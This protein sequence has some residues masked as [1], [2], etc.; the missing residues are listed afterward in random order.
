M[1]IPAARKT[2]ALAAVFALGLTAACGSDSDGDKSEDTSRDK[3][4]GATST[5]S[6]GS[7]DEGGKGDDGGK[8]GGDTPEGGDGKTLSAGQLDKVALATADVKDQGYKV[9]SPSPKQL[10]GRG[11]ETAERS[12]CQPLA[13]VIGGDPKPK[14]KHAAYRQIAN[15]KKAEAVPVFEYLNAHGTQ[16]NAVKTLADLRKAIDDCGDGFNASDADTDNRYASVKLLKAPKVGDDSLAYEVV[17]E[18]EGETI[19][20]HFVVSR[21]GATVV[22]FYSLNITK[23]A[24]TRVSDEVVTAQMDKFR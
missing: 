21:S 10:E 8:G 11:E 17:G 18:A 12:D 22:V 4:R 3:D 16:D 7:D 19:P 5:P 9:T 13:G 14:A 20:L 2:A 23:S 15:A 24:K 1:S 6:G